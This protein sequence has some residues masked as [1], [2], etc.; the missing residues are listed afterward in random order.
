MTKETTVEK[1]EEPALSTL[2]AA[3]VQ[4][5]TPAQA[6]SVMVQ[7]AYQFQGNHHDH[8]MIEQAAQVLSAT[9]Q[10]VSEPI[11]D[12]NGQPNRAQRRNAAKSPRGRTP[13]K[14][15]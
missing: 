13:K 5:M 9:V 2:P 6:L 4:P 11:A 15:N 10:A 3:A 7:A 8:L 14:T 12:S 1:V